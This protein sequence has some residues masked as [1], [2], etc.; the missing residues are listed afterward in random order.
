MTQVK[1]VGGR[2][3]RM[4]RAVLGMAEKPATSLRG[5][6]VAL[7][8]EQNLKA[9]HMARR[10]ATLAEIAEGIGW[11]YSL[12]TLRKKLIAIGVRSGGFRRGTHETRR[13]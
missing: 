5:R 8:R 2:R 7:T 12:D 10:E 4:A 11:Q 1:F 3:N 9:R 6:E 13:E